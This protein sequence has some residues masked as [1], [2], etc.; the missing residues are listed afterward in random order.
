MSGGVFPVVGGL[1]RQKPLY[2]GVIRFIPPLYISPRVI[3]LVLPL[4]YRFSTFLF[5]SFSANDFPSQIHVFP[6]SFVHVEHFWSSVCNFR[7]SSRQTLAG[8]GLS[9]VQWRFE[10]TENAFA[11]NNFIFL[12]ICENSVVQSPI[13]QIWAAIVLFLQIIGR[14]FIGGRNSNPD[15]QKCSAVWLVRPVGI[16]L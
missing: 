14:A 5:C 11:L 9:F 8:R 15:R 12:L 7:Y 10:V 6:R 3:F 4:S 13:W 1:S 16:G 2:A